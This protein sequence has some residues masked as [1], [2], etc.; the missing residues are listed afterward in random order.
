MLQDGDDPSTDPVFQGKPTLLPL[1]Y[2]T[3]AQLYKKG[4][5]PSID[6]QFMVEPRFENVALFLFRDG[7]L[8]DVSHKTVSDLDPD[9][10][11]LGRNIIETTFCNL[12]M[13]HQPTQSSKV[14]LLRH[15]LPTRPLPSSTKRVH[16]RASMPNLRWNQDSRM[17][18]YFNFEMDGWTMYRTRQFRTWIH[19]MTPWDE[20]SRPREG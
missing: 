9:Y 18:L 13:I 4:P 15:H 20:T 12:E 11:A 17:S 3:A 2:P 10:D 8:D 7:W 6:A 1:T 5:P 14:S 16:L 19:I